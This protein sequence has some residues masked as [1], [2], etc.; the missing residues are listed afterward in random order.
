MGSVNDTLSYCTFIGN[1]AVQAAGVYYNCDNGTLT[2]CTFTNNTATQWGGGVFFNRAGG[3]SNSIFTGNSANW[4]GGAIFWHVG[5]GYIVNCSFV[6]N[7]WI[8]SNGVYCNFD[9]IING[10]NGIVNIF[11]E[12][13][14]SG[15][16]VVVINNETYYY[17]PNTNINLADKFKNKRSRQR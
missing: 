14:L 12:G 13:T 16:S 10:G 1:H 15:I 6:N 5:N 8:K 17:P 3:L 2:G 7:K 9:L 4:N 11:T